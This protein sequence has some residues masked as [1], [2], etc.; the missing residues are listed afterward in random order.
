[1]PP[2]VARAGGVSR[3]DR[4]AGPDGRIAGLS[5][6][7]RP[8]SGATGMRPCG[9]LTAVNAV[10]AVRF[11]CF[12]LVGVAL[13]AGLAHLFALPNKI[14]LPGDAYLTVQQI[15]SGWVLL[16]LVA[17]GALAALGVLTA[18][19][20]R[21]PRTFPLTLAAF[22]SM[23]GAQGL[24]WALAFPVDQATAG[25]TTLPADWAILRDQWEYA[26]AAGAGLEL[27]AFAALVASVL[28]REHPTPPHDGHHR[29]RHGALE[30]MSVH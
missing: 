10:C 27:V 11:V 17:V 20:R 9:G 19:L 23:A 8:A 30:F 28:L 24:F 2:L 5:G 25:W 18:M 14:G 1:V 12:L 6:T 16:D 21:R 29:K 4:D 13:G 7:D 15:Y 3:A 26:H 22:L